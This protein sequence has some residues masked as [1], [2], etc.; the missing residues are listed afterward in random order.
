MR[1]QNQ[2]TPQVPELPV[3]PPP[4]GATVVTSGG[5]GRTITI[6]VPQTYAQVE[7]LVSRRD[8]L[9][10]QIQDAMDRRQG[11]VTQIQEAPD[12]VAR[13]GLEQQVALLDE[14]VDS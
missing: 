9:S 11:I 10:S 14:R 12:G 5:D 7:A 4:L 6:Q 8:Q 2:G 3:P 13:T 1:T